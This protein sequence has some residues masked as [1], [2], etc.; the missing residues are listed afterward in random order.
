M[1]PHLE[2]RIQKVVT[3]VGLHQ[4]SSDLSYWQSQTFEERLKA[5]ESI[6]HEFHLW[7]YGAEPRLQRVYRVIKLGAK[8]VDP[9]SYSKIDRTFIQ[10]N[11]LFDKPDDVSYW[12]TKTPEERWQAIELLRQ[13]LYGYDEST[14]RLQR[15]L[16]VVERA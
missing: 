7:R 11:S 1:K 8:A 3:K 5:L 4:K 9:E 13:T 10:E 16:E 15:V 6:R 2:R 12:L 14:G